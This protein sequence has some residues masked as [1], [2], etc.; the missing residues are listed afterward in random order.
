MAEREGQD[1]MSS[2]PLV[3]VVTP[4]YNGETYIA[5]CIESVLAQSYQHWD[6]TIVDNA[7][8][9]ATSE[10][11]RSYAARDP[12]IRHL[13]FDDFVDANRNH[14]RSFEAISPESEFCKM[15]QAD[16][17]LFPECIERMVGAASSS[18]T[19]GIVSA[20]QLVE[21]RLDLGG[22]PYDRSV[23]P[24]HEILRETLL[25]HMNVTGSP[26]AT[27]LRSDHVRARRPFWE[28]S[29]RHDDTE[30]MLWL[31]TRCDFAFVHQVLTFRRAQEGSRYRWS[32]S[33]NSHGA[34]DIIFLLRYGPSVLDETEY[35][36]RLRE[37]LRS[38]VWWHVR[39]FPRVLRLRDPEFF[40]LH[41]TE[42]R[43]ILANADGDRTVVAAMNIV[44]AL[45]AR[46]ALLR[47]DVS[48]EGARTS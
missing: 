21:R 19:I 9:D 18:D 14:N 23:Y 31:L 43:Q 24:G 15:V 32:E 39:Q 7:S 42:R 4:V 5:E 35:V 48:D 40:E 33:V 28:P 26:T 17:W 11:A 3:S 16:D 30:A 44:G 6:Y 2:P 1:A 29:L 45:L 47:H 46:Q 27:L 41:R 38:Y 25:G 20:Y 13:R 22:L 12:R 10:I 34:E 37:R 36:T 8:T